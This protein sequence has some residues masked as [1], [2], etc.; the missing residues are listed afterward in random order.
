MAPTQFTGLLWIGWLLYWM[1]A[2][3]NVKATR[4]R[5]SLLAGLGYRVPLILAMAILMVPDRVPAALLRRVAPATNVLPVGGTLVVM[6]G[7]AF[8]VWARWHLG[9][10][11]SGSVTVKEGHSLVRT[12]PYAFVRHPIYTGVLLAFAGTALQTGDWRGVLALALA[13]LSF[14][15]KL[16]LEERRMRETFPEDY[17]SYRRDTAR[18]VPWVW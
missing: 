16:R 12:G 3:R 11:W 17:D 7:L 4:R 9:R 5:E 6:I 13:A 1:A 14:T 2:A 8:S 15:L 18:L 10:N